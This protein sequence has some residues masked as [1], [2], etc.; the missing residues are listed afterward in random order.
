M[1]NMRMKTRLELTKLAEVVVS[2]WP[3]SEIRGTADFLGA[4]L[5]ELDNLSL[6]VDQQTIKKHIEWLEK[7]CMSLYR[8]SAPVVVKSSD[9]SVVSNIT[10]YSDGTYTIS[11]IIKQ[12]KITE[13][14]PPCKEYSMF[15]E[16]E[17][18]L[19]V[20]RGDYK[21]LYVREIDAQRWSGCA[22]GWSRYQ[23]KQNE[24]LGANRPGALTDDDKNVFL[25]IIAGK[26]V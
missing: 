5:I 12:P 18:G 25:D 13:Y 24:E 22:I 17:D 9:K 14:M 26:E 6:G 16:D 11:E 7:K 20:K 15:F 1:N 4:C 23:L 21:G 2:K 10:L 19:R 3:L 8:E